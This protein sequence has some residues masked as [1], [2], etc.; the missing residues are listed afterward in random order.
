MLDH[1]DR[2]RFRAQKVGVIAGG[3]SNERD[4]SL[5]TGAAFVD[6]LESLDYDVTTYDV[7]RDLGKLAEERPAAVILGLHGGS[8]ENGAIQG[9]L[10]M[11]GIPYTGS[12]VMAS[13]IA[14]DKARTKSL[15]NDRGI[16][17]PT[18]IFV[19]ASRFDSSAAHVYLRSV[20]LPCVAKLNDAG[21]SVGVHCCTDADQFEAVLEELGAQLTESS[22]SGVLFEELVDGP[23]YSVGFFDGV[24]LGAIEIRPAEGFY[25]YEAKYR[26]DTTK[27]LPVEDESLEDRLRTVGMATY[28]AIGCRG[29]AR[30]DVM[31]QPD[32]LKVL[33]VNTIPGMTATSLVPKMAARCGI[34]FEEF[35]ELMLA[36]AH[37]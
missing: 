5:D 15:L 8:G 2:G 14:M 36:S 30:V 35:T 20:P 3:D 23:E 1:L 32:N 22:S 31:G 4:V 37:L 13:A 11:A 26:A 16:P 7:P 21:S 9:F 19:P 17:A 24:Y 12:G 6:A 29:V 33:E 18:G 28:E 27:Y 10:E 25:D 34:E